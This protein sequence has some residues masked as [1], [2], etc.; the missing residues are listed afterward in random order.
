MSDEVVEFLDPFTHT[1]VEPVAPAP[2][3]APVA[4]Q[5]PAAAVIAA[6][7]P[8]PTNQLALPALL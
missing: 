2:I 4:I 3:V 1:P 5:I 8:T 6:P 7:A